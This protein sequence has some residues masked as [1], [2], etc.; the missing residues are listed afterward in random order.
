MESAEQPVNVSSKEIPDSLSSN[1]TSLALAYN[2]NWILSWTT[3][4]VKPHAKVR[5][6]GSVRT[7]GFEV[8]VNSNISVYF[9]QHNT[10]YF[11]PRLRNSR[12]FP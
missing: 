12:L 3:Y 11:K 7:N 2:V 10:N 9:R 5:I 4:T 6:T 1:K 8:G